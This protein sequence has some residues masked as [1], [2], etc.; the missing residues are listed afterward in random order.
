[1]W[2]IRKEMFSLWGI[3]YLT[4]GAARY[5]IDGASY[6]LS[7]GDLLC[8]PPGHI[9]V[10]NTWPNRL[11][12]CYVVEFSLAK[13]DTE[14]NSLP[15]PLVN[16]IGIKD[17]LIRLFNELACVW[18]DDSRPFYGIKARAILLFIFHRLFE[19]LVNDVPVSLD[20]TR[21][22]KVINHISRHYGEKISVRQMA[23]MTG[24]NT[25]YFGALFRQTTGMTMNRY[26]IKTRIKN[27][28]T[29]LH[30]GAHSIEETARRCGYNDKWHFCKQF[31]E[32]CG[33]SPSRCIPKKKIAGR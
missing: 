24:L 25:V 30:S 22:E 12:S 7:A 21:I 11:M 26:L 27:A 5:I 23:A 2:H 15:F 13:I 3:T 33:V 9:R 10:A 14:I 29:M 1:M 18:T 28:E 17:D 19:L 32:L 8:L 31:K 16:H 20:D 6:D 4:E